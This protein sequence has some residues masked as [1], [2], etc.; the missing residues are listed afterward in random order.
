MGECRGKPFPDR[1]FRVRRDIDDEP[2]IASKSFDHL[3]ASAFD[4][5]DA[6]TG[7]DFKNRRSSL[8]RDPVLGSRVVNNQRCHGCVPQDV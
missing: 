7:R 1:V 5:N 6:N 4:N 3:F 8:A 2:T